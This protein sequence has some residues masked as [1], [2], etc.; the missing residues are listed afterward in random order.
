MGQCLS[1]NL[2]EPA[3]IAMRIVGAFAYMVV[4][5]VIGGLGWLG[6]GGSSGFASPVVAI[7]LGTAT[8]LLYAVYLW[9]RADMD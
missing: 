8:G 4:G 6:F 2:K 9:I 7:A 3:M 1:G 5:G